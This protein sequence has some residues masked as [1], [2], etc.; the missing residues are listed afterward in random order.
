MLNSY[1]RTLLH[2]AWLIAA[3][4]GAACVV[5][6]HGLTPYPPDA[7]GDGRT[8][9]AGGAADQRDGVGD[10]DSS[11]DG[12]GG[13]R[14]GSGGT[15]GTGGQ[16][17]SAGG[18]GGG[19]G[20]T[21]DGGID[22]SPDDGSGGSRADASGSDGAADASSDGAQD[23]VADLSADIRGSDADAGSNDA[24]PDGGTDAVSQPPDAPPDTG[25]PK[26]AINEPYCG[27]GNRDP[28][29]ECDQGPANL[30]NPYGAGLCTTQCEIAP[31]C[32]DGT[33]DPQE[34][35]DLGS[36]NLPNPYGQ[37]TCSTLCRN[38]GY[39]GDGSTNGPEACDNGGSG[40]TDLG[41]CNPICTGY[42]EKKLIRRTNSFYS[43]NLGGPSGADAICQAEFGSAWKALIV[44]GSRRATVTPL[45]GDGQ[46][47]WVIQKYTHY[48]NYL[49]Q[50]IW[51]TDDLA[52]LG[53]R[54]GQ[55][56][57]IYANPFDLS[58]SYPWTGWENDWTTVAEDP[59]ISR[60]TCLGWTSVDP[61]W[62]ASF[63]MPDLTHGATELCGGSSFILCVQ[64]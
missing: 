20:T 58:G 28:G 63:C 54:N 35:C 56:L 36:G 4:L 49:D 60:G 52:L 32:G 39:C 15:G 9:D 41:A 21:H 24:S 23:V 30:P 46:Q 34:Q 62:R 38:G 43:T 37:G 22:G 10:G 11:T 26:D 13:G 25:S 50:F 64:Q 48:Y 27:D 16:G 33:R 45:A 53:V 31:Y 14:A 18:S 7:H 17:G 1:R 55:R 59:N 51:R 2:C 47:D 40:S 3:T 6:E 5:E 29:E 8:L 12:N 57:T 44:G 61:A 42:Y 19:A